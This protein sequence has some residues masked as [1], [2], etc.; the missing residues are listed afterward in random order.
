MQTFN[1]ASQVTYIRKLYNK[2][3]LSKINV[4]FM[5]TVPAVLKLSV[6]YSSDRSIPWT[7][8]VNSTYIRRSEDVLDV[9]G[10]SLTRSIYFLCPEGSDLFEQ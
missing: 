5:P 1:L 7:Q 2:Q 8:S 6:I 9:F 10:M 3:T 4:T